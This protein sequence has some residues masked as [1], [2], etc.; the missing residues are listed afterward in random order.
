MKKYWTVIDVFLNDVTHLWH[1]LGGVA[2]FF[3]V[4]TSSAATGSPIWAAGIHSTVATF[5]TMFSLEVK[6]KQY[7]NKIDWED[8]L[9]GMIF[10]IVFWIVLA[11]SSIVAL[12]SF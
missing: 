4:F 11:I 2:V 1:F 6:D 3:S 10:P 7:G 8:I 5:A 9:A 12:L